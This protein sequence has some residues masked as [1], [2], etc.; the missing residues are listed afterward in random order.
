MHSIT[1]IKQKRIT[2]ILILFCFFQCTL[3]PQ[4][5]T[6]TDASKKSGNEFDNENLEDN[7]FKTYRNQDELHNENQ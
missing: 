5:K 1:S 7:S 3:F 2:F 6:K 4:V